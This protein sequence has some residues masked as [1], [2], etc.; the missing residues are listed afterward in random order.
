M[1]KIINSLHFP[2]EKVAKKVDTFPQIKAEEVK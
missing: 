2:G 1:T